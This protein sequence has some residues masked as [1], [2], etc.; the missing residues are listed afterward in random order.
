MTK[1]WRQPQGESPGVGK[2]TIHTSGCRLP[3]DHEG[4]YVGIDFEQEAVDKLRDWLSEPPT[5]DRTLGGPDDSH[6]A[7]LG[8]AVQPLEVIEAWNLPFHL[9]NVV[10]YV[11]RWEAKG[12][13]RDLKV[14][15]F[16]LDR[17]IAQREQ[18]EQGGG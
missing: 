15:R 4:Y 14:A 2:G 8:D 16:Y 13:L 10:K 1:V 17:F 6:Y 7:R 11:A 3:S 9:G 18:R 5:T 12:G